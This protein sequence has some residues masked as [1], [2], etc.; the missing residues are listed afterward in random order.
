M[1]IFLKQS[2][3]DAAL[4]R[5]RWLFDEFPNLVVSYSGG[6]DSTVTL[7]LCLKV[8]EE[9]G[10][11]PLP[12]MFLDQ[13]AEWQLVID[14]VREVMYDPRV[15]PYWLQV[16]FK[17]TNATSGTADWLYAW[18]EGKENEWIHEKDPIAI[19]ENV[20]G[21]DRF[22]EIFGGFLNWLYPDQQ[23]CMVAGVRCSESPARMKGLTSFATYKWATWGKKR[24][25]KKKQFDF[26]PIYD[27][28]DSDVWKAIHDNKWPYCEIYDRM[29]QHGVPVRLM[30]V[31]NLHHETAVRVLFYVQEI[32]RET[33]NKLANR[34]QGV[35]S[36]KHL[37]D[38][39]IT[40]QE[41]PPM[42]KD[43][44]EY[45][46]FLLEKLIEDER[47]REI[48]RKQ[49][50][51]QDNLYDHPKALADLVKMQIGAIL[52]NDYENTKF[53]TFAASHA[54]YAKN[55]GKNGG[56]KGGIGDL[57]VNPTVHRGL[58]AAKS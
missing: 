15:K 35:N 30:R 34:L 38:D 48:M 33:W 46:D 36:V 53:S 23:A 50:A 58:D 10:R 25:E 57:H 19:T 51:N 7:N 54:R 2:V 41:L 17:I 56:L 28:D 44:R 22:A 52:V 1:K 13:E 18:E 26:Y 21:T 42:F 9:K 43:W 5:I 11:L 32:E 39:F 40:P 49:F 31:S 27:W 16:P 47:K 3:Y 4:D 24:N 14:H 37:R 29:Y 45:R 6:K 8:A 12:V 55:A 20:F